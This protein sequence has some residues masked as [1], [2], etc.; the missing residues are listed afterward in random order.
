MPGPKADKRIILAINPGTTST[1]TAIYLDSNPLFKE[2]IFHAS[3]EI[4]RFRKTYHQFEFRLAALKRS[5][6]KK[7]IPLEKL[8]AVAAVGGMLKPLPGGTYL[9]SER[10]VSDLRRGL[11]GEH[12]AN[13]GCLLAWR[14]SRE[15]GKPAYTVD[16]MVVDEL[17][18]LARIS[19][20]PQVTRKSIFHA[21]NHKAVGRRA[22]REL[23][24]EYRQANLVIAHLGGTISVGAHQG[25]KVIEVNNAIE[26]DGP[27]SLQSCGKLPLGE[28]LRFA[29][30]GRYSP[31]EI[32]HHLFQRGGLLGYLG[33]YDARKINELI[34][35]GH[36]TACQV[37]EALAYQVSKEIAACGAALKG[38]IDAVVLTGGLADD[39]RLISWIKERVSFLAP[40]LVYPGEDEMLALVEGALRVLE[41]K[42]EA[43]VY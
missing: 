10:M 6:A 42:E 12:A 20:L 36:G 2:T 5:L 16:P 33:T 8:D 34:D 1:R 27:F 31:P 11:Y 15:I 7:D 29:L 14:I 40:V 26:G 35:T 3:P 24:K 21:L 4:Q 28:L 39:T 43:G 9:V 32:Y 17:A 30:S 19:G 18:P 41:G 37:Y 25:G 38:K 13:L 23:G 22:S